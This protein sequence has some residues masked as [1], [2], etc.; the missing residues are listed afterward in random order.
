ML[1]KLRINMSGWFLYFVLWAIFLGIFMISR[2]GGTQDKVFEKFPITF[3][4]GLIFVIF[5]G[6]I[7]SLTDWALSLLVSKPWFS[8][9]PYVY[10]LLIKA[11]SLLL[12]FVMTQ[13]L[14]RVAM[15]FIVYEVKRQHLFHNFFGYLSSNRALSIIALIILF[16]LFT[17]LVVKMK[18]LIGG[19]ILFN[20]LIGRYRVPRT[21]KRIFMF[22][23][24]KDSTT[25]AETL[26]DSKFSKLIQ[27]VFDDL[28]EVVINKRAHIVK[29]V[30]DEVILSWDLKDGLSENNCIEFYFSYMDKLVSRSKYY[31]DNYNLVPEFKAGI[32]VGEATI[33]EIG[34][35]RKEIAYISD[36]L[37]TTARL[38]KECNIQGQKILISGDLKEVIDCRNEAKKITFSKVGFITLKGKKSAVDVYTVKTIAV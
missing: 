31:L 7:L 38:E 25:H 19:D 4:H 35:T 26:G 18:E 21:E 33:V 32:H 13:L 29:F 11:V 24:L 9:I 36:T 1:A 20:L 27:D 3:V 16:S 8:R 6:L 37:N 2:F 34:K 5:V 10:I 30:G 22:L 23:D 12:I 17:N 14:L 28:N 15:Y